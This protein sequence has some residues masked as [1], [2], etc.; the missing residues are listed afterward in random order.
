MSSPILNGRYAKTI[1]QA[2]KAVPP[3]SIP[4]ALQTQ[5]HSPSLWFSEVIRVA[6]LIGIVFLMTNKP[7]LVETLVASVTALL[8]G[9]IC[10]LL[11]TRTGRSGPAVEVS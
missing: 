3:G 4:P 11:L 6:L 5:L 2:A 7:E 8:L 9:L 10:A 1:F